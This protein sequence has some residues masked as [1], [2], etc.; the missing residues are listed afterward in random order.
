MLYKAHLKLEKDIFIE[1]E[2]KELAEYYAY[3]FG[4]VQIGNEIIY[5]ETTIS[6]PKRT[7]NILNIYRK[8]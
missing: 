2:D 6:M 5:P 3:D 7:D 4:I 8:S 1:A